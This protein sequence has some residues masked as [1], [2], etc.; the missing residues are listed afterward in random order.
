MVS[1]EAF[2]SHDRGPARPLRHSKPPFQQ[3]PSERRRMRPHWTRNLDLELFG[4]W[5]LDF[6]L[7]ALGFGL[8]ALGFGLWA[9]GSYMLDFT[10]PPL[11]LNDSQTQRLLDLTDSQTLRT[12]RLPMSYSSLSSLRIASSASITSWR[13]T[14]PLRNFNFRLNALLCGL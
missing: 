8:W 3:G 12:P 5:T 9:P 2:V 10:T 11:G 13:G 4:L 7:W 1:G 6:G 14:L